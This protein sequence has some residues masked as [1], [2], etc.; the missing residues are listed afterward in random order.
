[1]DTKK[2][3]NHTA[4]TPAQMAEQT[5]VSIETLRY[6]EREGLLQRVERAT[7]GH[8]RYSSADK[9]WVE[10]LRC[11]RDTGMSIE[12]LRTYCQLG[13]QGVHTQP[14]RLALLEEH[15]RLVLDEIETKKQAIERIDHKIQ[16]YT[17]QISMA[18]ATAKATQPIKG[19]PYER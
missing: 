18:G 6:Y 8:R 10:I 17:E 12:A 1:M 7:N 9:H 4:L 15:K 5:G 13:E 14:E 2:T 19:A 11:L 3:P 16:Y